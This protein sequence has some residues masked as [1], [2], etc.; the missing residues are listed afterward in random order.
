MSK[1][2]MIYELRIVKK[3][4]QIEKSLVLSTCQRY[5]KDYETILSHVETK[6]IVV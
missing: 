2:M 5:L 4:L 6:D 1:M 3:A